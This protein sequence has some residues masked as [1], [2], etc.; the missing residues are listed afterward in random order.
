MN[1]ESLYQQFAETYLN[2]HLE[3]HEGVEI[4]DISRAER[5]L[6]LRL[7][8]ALRSYYLVAGKADDLNK[9]HNIIRP[10]S[11]IE[12]D[13]G[14]VVFIDENQFVVSWGVRISLAAEDDPIIWQRNNTPPVEW[15]SEEKSFTEFMKD[16]FDWYRDAGVWNT[17]GL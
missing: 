9:A 17:T 5:R 13:N 3:E 7:P 12:L 2:R 15:F 6:C 4:A 8:K 16:M 14:F 10:V 11:E 1:Y